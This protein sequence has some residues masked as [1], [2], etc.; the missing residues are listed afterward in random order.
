MIVEVLAWFAPKWVYDYLYLLR[1]TTIMLTG[2]QLDGVGGTSNYAYKKS[3]QL[4]F[5]D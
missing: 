2:V 3:I 1:R 4:D 5:I